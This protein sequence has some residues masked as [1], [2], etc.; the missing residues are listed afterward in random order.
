MLSVQG[1][2]YHVGQFH[3]AKSCNYMYVLQHLYLG[4]Y[5]QAT[6]VWLTIAAGF[7]LIPADPFSIMIYLSD[8][9]A[10]SRLFRSN[11]GLW[12]YFFGTC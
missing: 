12:W 8:P 9:V 10:A 4:S 1:G 7:F 3:S 6:V 2:K 5:H 11:A